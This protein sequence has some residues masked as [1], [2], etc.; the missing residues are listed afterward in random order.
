MRPRLIVSDIDGT[1]I[2]SA[3]RVTPRLRAALLKAVEHA[4]FVLATGRP[5]RWV[6]TVLDQLPI[7]PL[8]VCA[9]GAVVYDSAQDRVIMQECVQPAAMA[10]IVARISAVLDC[11]FAVER[12]GES[13]FDRCDE[14]FVVTEDFVHAWESDEH[15]VAC[16]DDVVSA[17]AVKLLVRS[18][19]HSAAEMFALI[20]PVVPEELGHVTYSMGEGLIEVSA[21]GVTKAR[22]L[23]QVSALLGVDPADAVV[24]GDMPN[25]IQ[26][27]EWAGYSVA[28]GNAAQQVKDVADEVTT[29]ND[30]FG[31]ARVLE[32]MFGDV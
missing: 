23:A 11:G 3:E 13:A 26:M 21:P 14:L 29:S 31:V 28:M 27:F 30:D 16:L 20:R 17:P 19:R 12:A 6:Y 10:E 5:P 25:D 22:G 7:R 18:D 24:F 9:N 32:R 4:D 15:A 2:T 1:L 8:C